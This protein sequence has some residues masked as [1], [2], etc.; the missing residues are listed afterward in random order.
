MQDMNVT[1]SKPRKQKQN[2]YFYKPN[3][4]SSQTKKSKTLVYPS[5]DTER[6]LILCHHPI[7]PIIQTSLPYSPYPPIFIYV[8]QLLKHHRLHPPTF[9]HLYPPLLVL[10]THPPPEVPPIKLTQQPP[11]PLLHRLRSLHFLWSRTHPLLPR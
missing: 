8:P 2:K 6:N 7:V 3:K 4:T 11:L 5:Q 1:P 9:H 10:P